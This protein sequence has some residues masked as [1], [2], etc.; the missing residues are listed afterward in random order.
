M[1]NGSSGGI[2]IGTLLAIV[3]T[4]LK[5]CGVISWSW[6]WVL[7]PVWIPLGLVLILLVIAFVIGLS[8]NR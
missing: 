3:F 6:V 1:A 4:V 5:L 8:I 2:G 7:C